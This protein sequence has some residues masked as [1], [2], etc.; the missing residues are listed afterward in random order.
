MSGR[1]ETSALFLQVVAEHLTLQEISGLI[2][3]AETAKI[4]LF[5]EIGL[6]LLTT[7]NFDI[8]SEDK[9]SLKPFRTQLVIIVNRKETINNQRRALVKKPLIA[10]ILAKL[11]LQC[12][13]DFF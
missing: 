11:A 2:G 3:A 13:N 9:A 10:K 6:N 7:E 12:A 1:V 4:K 8:S 5:S